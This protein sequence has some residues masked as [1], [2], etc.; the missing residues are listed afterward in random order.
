MSDE[1]IVKYIR[2]QFD[3]TA[4]LENDANACAVAEW[5][6]GAGRGTHGNGMPLV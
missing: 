2:E 3:L 6:F 4:M 5:M 1:E